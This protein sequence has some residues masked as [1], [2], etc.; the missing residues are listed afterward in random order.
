MMFGLMVDHLNT[1]AKYQQESRDCYGIVKSSKIFIIHVLI[2]I[3][4]EYMLY[5]I[6]CQ[7]IGIIS[8]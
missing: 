3:L 6:T 8:K 1:I 2:D 7:P 5:L 4:Y